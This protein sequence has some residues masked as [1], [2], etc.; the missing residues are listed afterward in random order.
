MSRGIKDLR[1]LICVS[2][3]SYHDSND[4]LLSDDYTLSDGVDSLS[5]SSDGRGSRGSFAGS[6]SNHPQ[7]SAEEDCFDRSPD[8][9]CVPNTGSSPVQ[10]I[11]VK[12]TAN[13]SKKKKKKKKKTLNTLPIKHELPCSSPLPPVTSS[14]SCH[15]QSQSE[16]TSKTTDSE[17]S[18]HVRQKNTVKSRVINFDNM[19]A[20]MDAT[21]VSSWLTR[22]NEGISNISSFMDISI[23]FVQFAHFWLSEFPDNQKKEIFE[24]EYDILS[25]ETTF[26]F[27]VGID[28]RKV[29]ETDI[30]NL[31]AAIFHEY[32]N[33]LLGKNGGHLFLYYLNVLSSGRSN[34]YKK[35]L[36]EVKCSTQNRQYAQWI[37][38]TRSFSLVSIWSAVVNFYRNCKKRNDVLSEEVTVD[39]QVEIS[40][41]HLFQA[42]NL[43]Y[44]DVVHFLVGIWHV[45]PRL[46]DSHHRSLIFIAVMQGRVETLQYLLTMVSSFGKN[47]A[48]LGLKII[49]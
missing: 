32:P 40:E 43:G 23:H 37:L 6:L 26:A 5:L 34:E 48:P 17:A 27:A 46:L 2:R 10:N 28:Q 4:E 22:A 45:N 20:F 24:L 3:L 42:V 44:T 36:S 11:T 41:Q 49:H 19:L 35:L 21:I 47:L 7:E 29:S 13:H 25:E 39:S 14:K 15:S 38:A 1:E 9:G 31:I 18:E 33:K 16:V 30:M 8:S 12:E